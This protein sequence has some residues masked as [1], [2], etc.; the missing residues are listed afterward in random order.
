MIN[1]IIAKFKNIFS[2]KKDTDCCEWFT[3]ITIEGMQ[4]YRGSELAEMIKVGDKLN[5]KSQPDNKFDEN[6]IIVYWHQ[7]KIGYLP[8]S[9][10]SQ[11]K[12]KIAVDKNISAKIIEINPNNLD[13]KW[14][15]IKIYT[16]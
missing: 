6:A 14:I 2:T 7:N 11:V 4:H 1:K 16:I 13:R 8:K 10:A 15:K 5:L 12:E 9:I 3:D